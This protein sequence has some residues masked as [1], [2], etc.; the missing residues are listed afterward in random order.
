MTS[1][2]SSLGGLTHLT[3]SDY[4]LFSLRPHCSTT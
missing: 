2:G 1:L 4:E 3:H